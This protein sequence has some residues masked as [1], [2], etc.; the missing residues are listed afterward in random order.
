MWC[1]GAQASQDSGRRRA[2]G[3]IALPDYSDDE[4]DSVKGGEPNNDNAIQTAK[5]CRYKDTHRVLPPA[6]SPRAGYKQ[7]QNLGSREPSLVK[8]G[9]CNR[10]C[11]T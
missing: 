4:P 5:D 11:L 7:R 9:A 10:H 1:G 6:A 2:G 8:R 3:L